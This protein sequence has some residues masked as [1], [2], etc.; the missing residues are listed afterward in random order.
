[1]SK[2]ASHFSLVSAALIQGERNRRG[3][4]FWEGSQNVGVLWASYDKKLYS[5]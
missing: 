4:N 3:V 5:K 2:V 1:M